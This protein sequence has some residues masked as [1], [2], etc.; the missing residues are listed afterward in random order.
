MWVS[1]LTFG[2]FFVDVPCCLQC[3][4]FSPG[5]CRGGCRFSLYLFCNSSAEVIFVVSNLVLLFC[6]CKALRHEWIEWKCYFHNTLQQEHGEAQVRWCQLVFGGVE[7]TQMLDKVWSTKAVKCL[8][9]LPFTIL[10]AFF[11]YHLIMFFLRIV[12]IKEEINSDRWHL[13]SLHVSSP[14]HPFVFNS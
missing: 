1:K 4:L 13:C 6:T 2:K 9:Q 7:L 5:Y 12:I 3:H 8:L 11:V 14:L 10:F